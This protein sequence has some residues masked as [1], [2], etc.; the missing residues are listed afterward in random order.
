MN[1]DLTLTDTPI[2][3][4]ADIAEAAIASYGVLPVP[5]DMVRRVKPLGHC[6][7]SV[8]VSVEGAQASLHWDPHGRAVLIF[9]GTD[10]VS[11]WVYANFRLAYREVNGVRVHRGFWAYANAVCEKA[12][13]VLIEQGVWTRTTSFEFWGHSLGGGMAQAA[14]I[15]A[16]MQK[17][18]V[19]RVVTFCAPRVRRRS[20]KIAIRELNRVAAAEWIT[21]R[22]LG[23][24]VHDV[25]MSFPWLERLGTTAFG[26]VDEAEPDEIWWLDRNNR[27]RN[28]TVRERLADAARGVWSVLCE[29][30]TGVPSVPSLTGI[31]GWFHGLTPSGLACRLAA[32]RIGDHGRYATAL[33]AFAD[34]CETAGGEH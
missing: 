21:I 27:L 3:D 2:G 18:T 15:W 8:D 23:D 29:S 32:D 9:R 12:K 24:I 10:E 25:P 33:R 6:H 13:T 31:G 1:A 16:D 4:L 7:N 34:R 28:V 20:S 30:F 19:D 17:R 11:D 5:D 22:C 14:C 26:Y